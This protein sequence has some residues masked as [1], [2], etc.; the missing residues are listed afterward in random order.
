M[1]LN[2]KA[3]DSK[4]TGPQLAHAGKISGLAHAVFDE[5][6]AVIAGQSLRFHFFATGLQLAFV[7]APFGLH[8]LQLVSRQLHF[9]RFCSRWSWNGGWSRSRC[10][11]RGLGRS[12]MEATS[13]KQ[14]GS[15]TS[16]GAKH[17]DPLQFL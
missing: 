9:R 11:R 12:G 6:P 10:R 16:T 13:D 8:F 1:P 15:E 2:S 5:K 4:M 17:G 14:H 3:I 7:L